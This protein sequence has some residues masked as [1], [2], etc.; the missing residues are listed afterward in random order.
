MRAHLSFRDAAHADGPASRPAGTQRPQNTS[1][2][3]AAEHSGPVLTSCEKASARWSKQLATSLVSRTLKVTI[4]CCRCRADQGSRSS[5]T[6]SRAHRLGD[7]RS[8]CTWKRRVPLVRPMS[9]TSAF[10]LTCHR[11]RRCLRFPRDAAGL[12]ELVAQGRAL[13]CG[14]PIGPTKLAETRGSAARRLWGRRERW[15]GPTRGV[16]AQ[17]ITGA[18][19]GF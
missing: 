17:A 12:G 11:G 4:S 13:H 7:P 6:A 14:T 19:K 9:A 2:H 1:T 5:S 15:T 16:R 3:A 18:R 10:I 8:V